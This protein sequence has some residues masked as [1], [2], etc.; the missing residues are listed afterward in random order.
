MDPSFFWRPLSVDG[1]V[2]RELAAVLLKLI[3]E[4]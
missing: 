2:A 3:V 1:K 4:M